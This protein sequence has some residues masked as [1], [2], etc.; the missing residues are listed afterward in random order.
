VAKRLCIAAI[1]LVTLALGAGVLSAGVG[2]FLG[3]VAIE[4]DDE[5]VFNRHKMTLLADF[6]F[7]DPSGKKWIA[8][9]GGSLDGSSFPPLFE[10]MV[11]LPF[12]GEHRRASVLHD[13]FSQQMKEPWRDV[14]RMYYAAL[15]AEGT[16]ENEAKNAYAVLYG[17]APRWEVK[18]TS[19]CYSHCHVSAEALIWKPDVTES[20]LESA[21][22]T[23]S[24]GDPSLDEIERVVDASIPKPGPHLFS[25][26]RKEGT[27]PKA[28]SK[29]PED[30]NDDDTGDA[31]K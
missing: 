9:K 20:E 28:E 30:E 23:L 27:Q 1:T 2:T 21:L 7:Q 15:L 10:Q 19:T 4:W 22:E 26:L 12:T 18:G 11:A 31:Q 25:Q 5:D 29:Q 16:S 24:E 8:R 3:K 13:Y 6:A 14:R 17:V